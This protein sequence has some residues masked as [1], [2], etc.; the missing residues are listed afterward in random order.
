MKENT[1]THE[2]FV[3]GLRDARKMLDDFVNAANST[4][5]LS[6]PI[7][8][9]EHLSIQT[10]RG[11]E[12]VAIEV[13]RVERKLRPVYEGHDPYKGT[14]RRK[15]TGDYHCTHEEVAAMLRDSSEGSLDME[16]VEHSGLDDLDRDT[17]RS[18]RALY[19][20]SHK[21]G[22]VRKLPDDEFLR[23]I[24]S[25]IKCKDGIIRPTRAGL[26]MFGQEWCIVCDFPNY[27]LDYRKQL[28]DNRRWEDRFT[29]QDGE[30]SGNLF[31]FYE[32]A[33]DKLRQALE[34]PFRLEGIYRV[35]ETPAHEALREAIV[36]ALTNADYRSSR[37]VVFR[38][39]SGGI[40]LV[41]PGCFR[42][43][44][45]QAY[46]GG[47]SDARNKT[48]LKMFSL[49]KVGERAGSGVPNMVDQ[50]MS[51]GYGRPELSEEVDP[52]VSTTW[53]PLSKLTADEP[54]AESAVNVGSKAR[55]TT[56]DR[57]DSI[58]AYLSTHGESR[59]ADIAEDIG[60]G[61]SRTN[62]LLRGL[63]EGGIVEAVGGY[64]NRRYKLAGR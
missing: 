2:L 51:C 36:N 31:S 3:L 5:K 52:E 8:S 43:G 6:Y 53:L 22:K 17:I 59:S 19:D 4:D 11:R 35:D 29:S 46:A 16:P 60:L 20:E 12:V 44:V 15:F 56:A 25:A 54:G 14:Y 55:A 26:L 62:D 32:R 50:W 63:V 47:T 9:D 7:F 23:H 49:I 30:W 64:R 39:T 1:K 28:G 58:V 45:K 57:S 38:W 24:G 10:I 21:T 42:V 40:E 61:T 37:G 48:V 41:N 18:Y 33:Y 34:V 13:P 27:F